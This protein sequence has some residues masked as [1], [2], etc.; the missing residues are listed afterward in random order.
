MY[1][2]R[3]RCFGSMF[4]W[5][6]K[7]KPENCSSLGSMNLPAD[8]RPCGGG[9]WCRNPLR[10]SS[11]PK[12]FIALP[13]NTGVVRPAR[14]SSLSNSAPAMSSISSSSVILA[15]VS[16]GTRSFTK[17][18]KM[19]PT[20]TGAMYAPPVVRSNKCTCL[21]KRSNTPLKSAPSPIGQF[22][23]NGLS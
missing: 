18:S 5:I 4:A 15:K 10:I 3:S 7:M 11:T 8:G 13:K 9:A 16:S 2:M 14:I 23:G 12:L 19:S 20:S 21:A 22:T 6:L 1:A 17:S